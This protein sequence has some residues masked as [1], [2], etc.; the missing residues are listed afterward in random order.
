[1]EYFRHNVCCIAGGHTAKTPAT[2][3]YTSVVSHESLMIM[4]MPTSLNDLDNKQMIFIM[5]TSQHQLLKRLGWYVDR[6][7]AMALE[8][9]HCLSDIYMA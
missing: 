7:L 9:R 4:I 6:S 8:V 2:F 1:M 3:M 5:G